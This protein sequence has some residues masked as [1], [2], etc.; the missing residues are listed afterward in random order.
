ME[1][2]EYTGV[3]FDTYDVGTTREGYNVEDTYAKKLDTQHFN[4]NG[5]ILRVW[6]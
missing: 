5:D 1:D 2:T 3:D 4:Y 6:I